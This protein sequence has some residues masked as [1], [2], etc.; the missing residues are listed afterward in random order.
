MWVLNLC[1]LSEKFGIIF[2]TCDKDVYAFKAKA[3]YEKEYE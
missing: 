1:V 3:R 2:V